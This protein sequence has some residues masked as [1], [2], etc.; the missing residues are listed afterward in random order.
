MGTSTSQPSPASSN[1]WRL[2]RALL[3]KVG[4]TPEQQSAE[5]WRAAV[6]DREPE[7]LASLGSPVLAEA[8]FLAGSA[9]SP[10]EALRAFDAGLESRKA[11]D[12]VFDMGRRALVRAVAARIG[13]GGF[14][15]EL[16]AEAVGYYVA[17]DMAGIVGS[18]GRV[19]TI[20]AAAALKHQISD[21]A[22]NA[23]RLGGTPTADND[24]WRDYVARVLGVLQQREPEGSSRPASR[25]GRS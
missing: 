9:S 25:K 23:T 5:L 15:A 19:P 8:A 14:A 13:T 24:S 16:F 7:L 21:V 10:I 11:A 22:R 18:R 12:L 2:A 4:V 17:R 6:A 3:G 1:N 20:G